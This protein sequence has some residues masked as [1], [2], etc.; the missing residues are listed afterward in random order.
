MLYFSY[1]LTYRV[2]V[3]ELAKQAFVHFLLEGVT[4]RFVVG[5][6]CEMPTSGHVAKIFNIKVNGE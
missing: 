1:H 5:E 4:Q 2:K 3:A 6:N